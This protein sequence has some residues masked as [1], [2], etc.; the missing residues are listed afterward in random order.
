MD[1]ARALIAFIVRERSRS[2]LSSCPAAVR[3]MYAGMEVVEV[4]HL[5]F[6]RLP[7]KELGVSC[8]VCRLWREVAEGEHLWRTLCSDRWPGCMKKDARKVIEAM[9]GFRAFFSRRALAMSRPPKQLPPRPWLRLEHLTFFVDL[10][11][12]GIPVISEVLS[13]SNINQAFSMGLQIDPSVM[14]DSILPRQALT[15]LFYQ[16]QLYYEK[17]FQTMHTSKYWLNWSVVRSTDHKMVCLLHSAPVPD[18]VLPW[19]E[20]EGEDG[21]DEYCLPLLFQAELVGDAILSTGS[22]RQPPLLTFA[23]LDCRP[24][25]GDSL[26]DPMRFELVELQLGVWKRDEKCAPPIERVLLTLQELD[27]K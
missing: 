5:V 2:I 20:E 14:T 24:V 6:A 21:G 11:Y 19:E 27:W 9:G 25:W 12:N 10:T 18:G 26:S 16:G 15:P 22:L 17:P 1:D 13:G 7:E 3:T 4:L 8:C 23:C